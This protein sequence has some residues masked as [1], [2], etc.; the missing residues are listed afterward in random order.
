[1]LKRL[2]N[3]SK[4]LITTAELAV[5][6]MPKQ[7]DALEMNERLAYYAFLLRIQASIEELKKA[8][9]IRQESDLENFLQKQNQLIEEALIQLNVSVPVKVRDELR[10][11]YRLVFRQA[12]RLT[13]FGAESKVS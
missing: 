10:D 8:V 3:I 2:H 5:E 7:D 13:L 12:E 9:K 6:M 4:S 1:M 11:K